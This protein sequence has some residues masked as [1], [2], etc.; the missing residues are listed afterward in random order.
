MQQG[1]AKTVRGNRMRAGM[2]Y[3]QRRRKLDEAIRM[4]AAINDQNRVVVRRSINEH[5]RV[6]TIHKVMK[7]KC[8]VEPIELS[9]KNL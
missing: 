3:H 2:T 8:S 5:K 1:P 4:D 7:E 6:P 9:T